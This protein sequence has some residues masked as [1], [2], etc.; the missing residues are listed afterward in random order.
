MD[1]C[2]LAPARGRFFWGV[3]ALEEWPRIL[4]Y[5]WSLPVMYTVAHIRRA[6]KGMGSWGSRRCTRLGLG[7]GNFL[8]FFAGVRPGGCW[9]RGVPKVTS[10]ALE[11]HVTR[12]GSILRS[13]PS[14]QRA[15]SNKLAPYPPKGSFSKEP[16]KPTSTNQNPTRGAVAPKALAHALSN[17]NH[18]FVGL[19]CI[20]YMGRHHKSL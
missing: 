11:S 1:G 4:E 7:E 9:G 12:K 20:L 13:G 8:S 2:L 17:R 5:I 14:L 6:A 18:L 3:L 16:K 10:L 15:S 19:L